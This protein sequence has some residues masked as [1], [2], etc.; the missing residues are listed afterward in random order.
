[1]ETLTWILVQSRTNKFV[2]E[3]ISLLYPKLQS[4]GIHRDPLDEIG[5]RLGNIPPKKF[6]SGIYTPLPPRR[7]RF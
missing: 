1:M 7:E 5:S 2:L 6:E 3:K 4:P